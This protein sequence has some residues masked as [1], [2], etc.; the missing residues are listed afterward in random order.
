M[1]FKYLDIDL[2]KENFILP[3][4]ARIDDFLLKNHSNEIMKAIDF[5][6]TDGKLLYVHGFL[7][8][9]KRQFI[10]VKILYKYR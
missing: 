8:T 5:M 2:D 6:N 9:G 3:S 7:G 4:S 10:F 1:E